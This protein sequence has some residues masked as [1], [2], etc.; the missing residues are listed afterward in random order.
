MYK[1]R[2]TDQ[3][4]IIQLRSVLKCYLSKLINVLMSPELQL[5]TAKTIHFNN[6]K[7]KEYL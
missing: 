2:L 4:I 3:V 7:H 5:K 1:N 6:I